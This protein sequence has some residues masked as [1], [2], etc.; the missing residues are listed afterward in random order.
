M[1]PEY[2]FGALRM[3]FYLEDGKDR[4]LMEVK[5]V[6]LEQDGIGYFPDAP[7]ERGV[8]HLNELAAALGCRMSP[9]EVTIDWAAQ[10][11]R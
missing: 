8:R 10:K 2:T 4:I 9:E 3:D 1:K 5:R 7:T 6:T 11:Q